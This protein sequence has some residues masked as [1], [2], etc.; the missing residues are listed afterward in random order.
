[1]FIKIFHVILY[2]FIAL[3]DC[4][5]K[6]LHNKRRYPTVRFSFI[7][8]SPRNEENKIKIY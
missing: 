4:N 3:Y 8:R 2:N 7:V 5:K 6:V 1:M